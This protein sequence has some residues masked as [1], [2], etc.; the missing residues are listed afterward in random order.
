[1]RGGGVGSRDLWSVWRCLFYRAP[2]FVMEKR[3]GDGCG[4]PGNGGLFVC[5]SV[6]LFLGQV[7]RYEVGVVRGGVM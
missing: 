2:G 3:G 1:M 5:L 7:P 6:C 4:W